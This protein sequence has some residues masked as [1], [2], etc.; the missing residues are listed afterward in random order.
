MIEQKKALARARSSAPAR[1]GLTE[2]ST[3]ALREVLAL[4]PDAVVGMNA[5]SS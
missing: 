4:S 1:A 3:A 2:L 5:V